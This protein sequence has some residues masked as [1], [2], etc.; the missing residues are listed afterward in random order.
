MDK[1]VVTLLGLVVVAGIVWFFW[2][3]RRAGARAA[4]SAGGYQ[5]ASITV[6][7]A[8]V[9]D[10]VV[11]LAGRPVRLRFTRRE[12]S[13]C[14]ETVVFGDFGKSARLPEGEEVAVELLPR[15]PGTYEFTCAMGMLRGHLV[16]E[17]AT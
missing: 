12:S 8:Y 13:P 15:E 7:G 2:G 4:V 1:L 5:E 3:P 17:P 16:V 11:V 9:P 10:T 6:K 14:S